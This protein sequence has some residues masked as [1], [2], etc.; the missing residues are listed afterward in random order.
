M[1]KLWDNKPKNQIDLSV[2]GD[3]STCRGLCDTIWLLE[4]S[5][6]HGKPWITY[7]TAWIMTNKI[8]ANGPIVSSYGGYK[9]KLSDGR[10]RADFC[11]KMAEMIDR[12]KELAKRKK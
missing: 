3:F 6:R 1:A 12:Q 5:E 2:S 11:R 8:H 10:S 9:W 4:G 7:N